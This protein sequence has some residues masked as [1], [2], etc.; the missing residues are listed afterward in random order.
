MD[1]KFVKEWMEQIERRLEA[2]EGKKAAP[3][4]APPP[5]APRDSFPR[6]VYRRS[7]TTGE[8]EGMLV[9]SAAEMPPE[10]SY[11]DSPAEL[12]DLDDTQAA[13]IDLE[14]EAE[15]ELVVDAPEVEPAPVTDETE[16]FAGPPIPDDWAEKGTGTH[17][18]RIKLAKLIMPD[19]ADA[20]K[21]D[22]DAIVI[23]ESELERRGN[24]N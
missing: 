18:K 11:V 3:P 12:D 21:T 8:A 17:F 13:M 9:N 7:P 23:I 1:E 4:P 16:V 5:T 6:W 10:G 22:E 2:L 14:P 24:I 20:I 15:T 19:M